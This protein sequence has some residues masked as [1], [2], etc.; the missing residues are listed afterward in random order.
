M[1][2][3][4]YIILFYIIL[5]IISPENIFEIN[6]AILS[7]KNIIKLRKTSSKNVWNEF[8]LKVNN[9]IFTK[10]L[11][12]KLFNKFW[13]TIENNFTNV[14]HMFI[15]LKIKYNNGDFVTIGKLQRLN[16]TDKQWFIDFIIDNM[17]FKS[18]YYNETQI[19]SIIFSYGFKKGKIE[20]KNAIKSDLTFQKY[21]NH[22]LVISFNPLDF[23]KIISISKLNNETLYILQD[24]DNLIIKILSSENQN[25]IEIF[26]NAYLIIKFTDLKLSESKFIRIIDNK[27]YYFENNEEILFMK[28][29]KTRFISKTNKS[30]NL[31]NKFITLD[32]E[33]YIKDNVLIPFCISIF[34]GKKSYSFFITDFK[35]TE[36]LI[37]T[38]LRS[39]LSRKYNGYNVYMHNMAKF[40]IIFLLK[41]LL[42]LGNV[43]PI[44]HNGRIISINLNFG[45]N[46][47]Y[48][49]QFKDSY[50]ILLA[51]LAK[52]TKGFMVKTLKTIFPFLFV[53]ENNLNYIGN[54][55]EFNFFG[56]K[57]NYEE[58]KEYYSKFN[59]WNL[60]K[61]TIN[62]CE[63]DC[64]SLHQVIFKFSELIFDLFGKN[65]HHYPTLPS[66][67]FAIFRS[68]FMEDNLIPQLSGKIAKDIRSGYTGGAVDMYIPEGEVVYAYDVNSLYPFV[69]KEYP[70][71]TGKPVYFE[72]DI[73]ATVPNAFGFFY[74]KIIAPDDIKHPILQTHVKTTNGI[75]TIS[76]IGTWED[77]LFSEE[78]KNALNY[79]YKIEILWG[80]TFDSGYIFKDYVDFLYNL[81]SNYSKSDPMNFIAKIL[82]NSLYGRFG[83]NDN[84]PNINIIHK[85]YY[86][87]FENKFLDD[88]IDKVE[89]DESWLVFYKSTNLDDIGS[90][91]VSISIA[92]AITAY[93]RIHMTQ[94]KNNPLINLY[95]TDTD[96]I[97]T[98]SEIDE[99]LIDN[100]TLGK[101]KLEN[102]ADKAIFLAP[103]V[104]CLKLENSETVYKAKGLKHEVELT[105]ND[106]EKLLYKNS[107]LKKSQLKM[108]KYLNK[109]YIEVLEQV[110]TLQVTDNKRQLIYNVNNKLVATEAYKISETKTIKLHY[111]PFIIFNLRQKL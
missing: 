111:P 33:T 101:L 27:R 93:A 74:C 77:M 46:L 80:Y 105:M 10:D 45:K 15:L 58:Y 44:I 83:M 2:I 48:R 85:D 110:Y 19:E 103:K 79:G 4:F 56:N 6:M 49:L 82:L 37:L 38:A 99:S 86:A 36:D 24:K 59:R 52:L 25:S 14:N 5:F 62:Y 20:N 53:N 29:T 9:K 100:K 66:L 78:L 34:D 104:Y 30:K 72:G 98:D 106:F 51:S 26:K 39:I 96:S 28:E 73:R 84:F 71:P 23:G 32:I 97:Y 60:K 17:E 64:I 107:L 69:M 76:P 109:S 57:T 50:L 81:R 55:L 47:E 35:S 18:E 12:E 94:F 22:N 67:A 75:R 11:F 42:K 40:D 3:L 16:F 7:S 31:V 8:I 87:D 1:F 91:N 90:H 65:V 61:E 63:I 13:V 89:L 102:I 41:H 95:Y 92:A 54:V 108:R 21:N 68:N 43:S 70:M 88:I